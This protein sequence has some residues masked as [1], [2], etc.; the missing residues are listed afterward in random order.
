MLFG[1]LTVNTYK[2]VSM[3]RV[4]AERMSGFW[5][6]VYGKKVY[7][8]LIGDADVSYNIA[9]TF[10]NHA[11]RWL[12]DAGIKFS[13]ESFS[14]EDYYPYS[15]GIIQTASMLFVLSYQGSI[16]MV[17]N[18]TQ[19]LAQILARVYVRSVKNMY[20]NHAGGTLPKKSD[21]TLRRI[22]SSK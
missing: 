4:A 22:K 12:R 7:I 18:C 13:P 5:R 10:R 1:F 9:A 16:V 14:Y 21:Y 8:R 15:K 11:K 20:K 6:V 17:M 3:K 2:E 19:E